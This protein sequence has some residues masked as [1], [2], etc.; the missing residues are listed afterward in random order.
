MGGVLL[1]T[2]REGFISSVQLGRSVVEIMNKM[3]TID[4][5]HEGISERNNLDQYGLGGLGKTS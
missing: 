4:E 5:V 1:S 3:P 2:E